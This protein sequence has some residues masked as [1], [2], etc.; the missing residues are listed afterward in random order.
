MNPIGKLVS[1]MGQKMILAVF[2]AADLD[3]P[4]GDPLVLDVTDFDTSSLNA[5]VD[6]CETIANDSISDY[7]DFCFGRG[8]YLPFHIIIV[9][10]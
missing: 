9:H 3:Q 5:R 7:R 6:T 4:P 1:E 8:S 2:F 10:K